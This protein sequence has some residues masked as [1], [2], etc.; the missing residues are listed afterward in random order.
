[1]PRRTLRG[2]GGAVEKSPHRDRRS[3]KVAAVLGPALPE[4]GSALMMGLNGLIPVVSVEEDCAALDFPRASFY[5]KRVLDFAPALAAVM[6]SVLA[7]ALA[8]AERESV[9]A[10]LHEEHFQ[11]TSPAAVYATLL[12]KSAYHC[13]IRTM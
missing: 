7:R 10:C 4:N 11:N 5:R 1:M 6:K 9:L 2:A 13:S 8:P 3:K 12:D